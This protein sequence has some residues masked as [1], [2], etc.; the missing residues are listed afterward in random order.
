[1]TP[2]VD[3]IHQAVT[4]AL[5]SC[6]LDSRR[7]YTSVTAVPPGGDRVAVE[8]SD[9]GVLRAISERLGETA[10]VELRDLPEAAA[11][12]RALIA[13]S[14]VAD[15]R[16][17][18]SHASE[19]AS[20]AIHGDAVVPLKREGDWVLA[21]MDDG[22]IG[23]IRSWHLREI[24]RE[25]LARFDALARHR[26]AA[27]HAELCE[28]PAAGAL[29]VMDLVAGTRVR[30]AGGGPRGWRSVS[31]ADGTS[32]FVRSSSVESVPDPLVP[33]RARL[34][35]TALRFLGVPYLWGGT[36]S[37]GFDCSGLV[38]R[39]FRLN[40]LLLPRDSDLQA[41]FGVPL[42]DSSRAPEAGN[43][44]FFGAAGGP[45]THVALAVLGGLFVHAYGQVRVGSLDP[46]HP[47]FEPNLHKIWRL[48]T[49]PLGAPRAGR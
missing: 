15:V 24:P 46:V 33:S 16:R 28:E 4:D 30:A 31:L 47:H 7:C 22:Y 26:V 36:T 10:G 43:L 44:M 41:D 13:A 42:T 2:S 40:G 19:L 20:Q 32:G 29:P 38:Q 48:N 11:G 12:E 27:R 25:E 21:R 35:A 34:A 8:C 37:N 18:P 5:A 49:D 1:M 9:A 14:S 3:R 45:I 6:R 23:W 17:E 39:V